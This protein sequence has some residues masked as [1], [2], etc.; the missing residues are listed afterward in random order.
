V[1]RAG[2][3]G[4]PNSI[5]SSPDGRRLSVRFHIKRMW[6][7]EG[8]ARIVIVAKDRIRSR[9]ALLAASG[10]SRPS[11]EYYCVTI[12]CPDLIPTSTPPPPHLADAR[13]EASPTAAL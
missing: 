7:I 12:S 2:P 4:N 6:S 1:G 3:T 5:G 9:Y 8:V 13:R 10:P 11:L